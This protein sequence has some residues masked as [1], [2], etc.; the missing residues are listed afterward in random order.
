MSYFE[1][2]TPELVRWL[3]QQPSTAF[4]PSGL[5]YPDRLANV[6]NYLARDVYPHVERAALLTEHGYLTDHGEA[7]IRTLIGRA[8]AL[9]YADGAPQFDPYEIYLLLQAAHFH[10]VGNIYGRAGHERRMSDV[11]AALGPLLGDDAPERRAIQQIAGAHGGT[12]DGSRDT[13]TI[14]PPFEHVLNKPVRFQALA[15]TLRFAD[16]LADDY[17]RAARFLLEHNQI[18]QSSEV[19]HKYA[20]ALH[21]VVVNRDHRTVRL[22][23]QFTKDD[24]T[25]LFGKAQ[26]T[27]FLLDEI[28][29]RTLKMHFERIYCMR[30]MWDVARLDSIEVRIRIYNDNSS[31][32]PMR[33]PIGYRLAERG[34]P[35]HVEAHITD[36]CPD[37][38]LTGQTLCNQLR[39][40]T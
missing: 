30:F 15:A 40:A 3:V 28:Y 1:R 32:S 17:T 38:A 37:V 21:S 9:I 34:Y 12:I 27:V 25:R 8:A 39:D 22:E 19:F 35:D 18:P 11:I 24:A 23:F 29:A 2:D 7:H 13:I 20:H 5:P 14:L 36:V 16:E 31:P 4:P 33:D 10:D 6:F 26:S